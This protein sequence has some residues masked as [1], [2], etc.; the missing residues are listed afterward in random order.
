MPIKE[1]REARKLKKISRKD[2]SKQLNIKFNLI[3]NFET[4][5]E[6]E[7]LMNI[8]LAEKENLFKL[9]IYFDLNFKNLITSNGLSMNSFNTLYSQSFPIEGKEEIYFSSWQSFLKYYLE[10]IFQKFDTELIW[11]GQENPKWLLKSSLVRSYSDEI[12][13][14][15][16]DVIFNYFKEA[17]KGKTE[18]INLEHIE[19]FNSG[20]KINNKVESNEIKSKTEMYKFLS[21]G[22]HHGL[23]IPLMDWTKSPFIGAY[24][25]FSNLN[26]TESNYRVI[27][28]INKSLLLDILE[29]NDEVK[30]LEE[31]T[32]FNLRLINQQGMFIYGPLKTDLESWL[33]D[34]YKKK[35]LEDNPEIKLFGINLSEKKII[36]Y[37]FLIPN[38]DKNSIMKFLNTMN[39]NPTTLFPDVSG[40][41]KAANL[42]LELN[43][44]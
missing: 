41:A 22:Q 27:Y 38:Y 8:C 1:L 31:R 39:I 28:A 6:E 10:N 18:A 35:Y 33:L 5:S 32:H 15:T 36:L 4:L 17:L 43:T 30:L 24:F 44:I 34:Q 16:V 23:K 29:T 42:N 14:E 20:V 9:S 11:R 7:K 3:K 12:G 25:A 19:F 21:L 40:A 13:E 26:Y 2:L 37:K